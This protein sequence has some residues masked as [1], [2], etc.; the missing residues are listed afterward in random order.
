[1]SPKNFCICN[2]LN[3]HVINHPL[4]QKFLNYSGGLLCFMGIMLIIITL[5]NRD[6][7]CLILLILYSIL[8]FYD[9]F[10][11]IFLSLFFFL[12]L[13]LYLYLSL[14]LSFLPSLTVAL[15][16]T[17]SHTLSLSIPLPFTF[18]LYDCVSSSLFLLQIVA[19][20]QEKFKSLAP[21]IPFLHLRHVQ[22]DENNGYFKLC[23]HFRWA[24][25]M[26]RFYVLTTTI[27]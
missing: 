9:F 15:A 7:V 12:Y 14:A 8:W 2:V 23:S 6:D 16:D 27:F 26:V 4:L 17:F 3:F 11:F 5:I 22:S 18:P 25:N 19:A 24:L 20:A 10:Y 1:M 21:T 13:Y